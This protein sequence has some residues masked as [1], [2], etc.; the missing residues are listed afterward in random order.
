GR[1]DQGPPGPAERSW[2]VVGPD[3]PAGTGTA[4][5]DVPQADP[6]VLP[7]KGAGVLGRSIPHDSGA[8][9]VS[10]RATYL[11]DLTPVRGE[12]LVE[13]VGSPRAHARI[14]AVDV[15]AARRVEGV[16]AALTHADVPGSNR[17]GAEVE[18][19]E[20]LAERTCR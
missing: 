5:D 2:R 4:R 20:V 17:F 15:A 16:A 14:K 3:P 18:D 7:P 11:A 10:G 13:F 9:H 8:L 1:L 6:R 19:E 12:L